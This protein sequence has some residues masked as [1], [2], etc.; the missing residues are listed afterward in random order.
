MSVEEQKVTFLLSS[1]CIY[2]HI[3]QVEE[4]EIKIVNSYT[5]YFILKPTKDL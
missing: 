5:F 2:S 4:A 1:D 3:R